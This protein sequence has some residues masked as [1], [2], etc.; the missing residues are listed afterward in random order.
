[1]SNLNK[2][3]KEVTNLNKIDDTGVFNG[4]MILKEYDFFS[5]GNVKILYPS[6]E[7]INDILTIMTKSAVVDEE[8]REIVIDLDIYKIVYELLPIVTNIDVSDVTRDN[9]KHYVDIGHP[10][11][12]EVVNDVSAIVNSLAELFHSILNDKLKK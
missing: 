10:E 4:R 12:L 7:D 5:M 6:Q 8:S 11:F 3:D 9:I 2:D 1:M